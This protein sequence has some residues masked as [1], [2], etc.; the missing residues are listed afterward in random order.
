MYWT[1]LQNSFLLTGK[2]PNEWSE[3]LNGEAE[4]ICK[5]A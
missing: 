2:I 3:P 1:C 4:R 5:D